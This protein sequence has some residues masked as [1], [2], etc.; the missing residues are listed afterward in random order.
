DTTAF[1]DQLIAQGLAEVERRAREEAEKLLNGAAEEALDAVEE[2][3][4]IEVPTTDTPDDVEEILRKSADDA[5]RGA[6]GR[7]GGKRR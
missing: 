5:L 3:T 2:A 1:T 4:G 7:F 6:L